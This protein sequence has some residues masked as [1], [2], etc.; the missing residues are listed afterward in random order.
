MFKT[1]SLVTISFLLVG[2]STKIPITNISN[3]S[4][5]TN[6][7]ESILITNNNDNTL[8]NLKFD[9][10]QTL[11]N[12]GTLIN[13]PYTFNLNLINF[14]NHSNINEFYQKTESF[15]KDKNCQRTNSFLRV[16]ELDYRNY[17]NNRYDNRKQPY[18]EQNCIIEKIEI[19]KCYE[20]NT[21]SVL[22]TNTINNISKRND[23]NNFSS[24]S[25]SVYCTLNENNRIIDDLEF[26]N[27]NRNIS[28]IKDSVID[29]IKPNISIQFISVYETVDSL[30]L[31]SLDKNNFE[32]AIELIDDKNFK[33]SESLLLTIYNNAL[34]KYGKIPYEI[35][36]NLA[37][38]NEN[39]GNSSIAL[40]YYQEINEINVQNHIRRIQNLNK[41]N[42]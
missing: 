39:L 11:I 40:K 16:N 9:L 7:N 23:S 6:K 20:V 5:I 38:V 14:N 37:L 30:N 26:N 24:S 3:N 10:N 21:D 34:N 41:Y 33:Q 2:C 1:L 4:L 25:S 12:S 18:Q 22:L 36:F 42:K 32:K 15:I 17:K 31:D 29:Y 19:Q 35:K 27:I 13:A 28:I 8:N